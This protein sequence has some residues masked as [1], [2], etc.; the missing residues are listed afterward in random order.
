M[1]STGPN[2]ERTITESAGARSGRPRRQ[3]CDCREGRTQ[4]PTALS[5]LGAQLGRYCPQIRKHSIRRPRHSPRLDKHCIRRAASTPPLHFGAFPGIFRRLAST[6]CDAYRREVRQ[7]AMKVWMVM[8]AQ[9]IFLSQGNVRKTTIAQ[10]AA[11]MRGAK[12]IAN[13]E[14]RSAVLQNTERQ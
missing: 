14:R 3:S 4:E 7:C 1:G 8:I 2:A 5:V 13:T 11:L 6:H 9:T 12:R 10:Q